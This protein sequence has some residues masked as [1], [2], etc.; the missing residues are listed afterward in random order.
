MLFGG[1]NTDPRSTVNKFLHHDQY[2]KR[3]VHGS[4]E[5]PSC[6]SSLKEL[7]ARLSS[8]KSPFR[9]VDLRGLPDIE[10]SDDKLSGI[11]HSSSKL[12]IQSTAA[13]AKLINILSEERMNILCL[14]REPNPKKAGKHDSAKQSF[15]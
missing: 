1:N 4:G 6:H 15:K 12:Q 10:R 13:A 8:S 14:E 5:Y 7:T 11:S 9:H 2:Y 3:L